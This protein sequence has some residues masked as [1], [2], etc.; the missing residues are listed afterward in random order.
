MEGIGNEVASTSEEV[1]SKLAVRVR[2]SKGNE[3]VAITI[4]PM[5]IIMG[6]PILSIAWRTSC[7]L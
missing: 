4:F 6:M 3:I 2:V 7:N 5:I 1:T